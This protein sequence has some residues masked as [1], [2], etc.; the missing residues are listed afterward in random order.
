MFFPGM[1]EEQKAKQVRVCSR[2]HIADGDDDDDDEGGSGIHAFFY[3]T[4]VQLQLPRNQPQLT[5]F[6]SDSLVEIHQQSNRI[7]LSWIP[8]N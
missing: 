1:D 2:A 6:D 5:S 4:E 7:L 3:Y 8:L